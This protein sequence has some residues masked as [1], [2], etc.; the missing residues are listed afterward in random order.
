M[1][2]RYTDIY[3]DLKNR[4]IMGTYQVGDKLPSE[5]ELCKIYNSSRGTIRKA[6]DLLAEE[7]LVNSMHGK[8]VF[9]LNNDLITFSV[10]RLVSFKEASESSGQKFSTTVAHFTVVEIDEALSQKTNLPV[11]KHA[12]HMYRIRHLN[13][14]RVI[15][16]VN[17]F[18]TDVVVGLTEEIAENSVYEYIEEQLNAK[19]GFANRVI[20]VELATAK[21]KEHLDLKYYDVVAVVKNLVHLH[22]GT[23][24][25]YTESRHRPDRF[26][27]SDF[28][29]RR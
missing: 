4:I 2:T 25:E 20:H 27:F 6:L 12:Y 28:S 14:E 26:E 9:V 29:R 8:G 15:L 1:R 16:D 19:V 11:G 13:G 17:Y 23:P 10:G 5:N 21:D 7:G 3:E 18:L 22:D 24:F